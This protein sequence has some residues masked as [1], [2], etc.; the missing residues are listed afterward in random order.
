MSINRVALRNLGRNRVK[1]LLS[2]IAIIAGVAAYI[3]SS[4]FQK[5]MA[6]NGFLNI[7]NY[8]SGPIQ[9]YSKDYFE[10]KDEFPL[11]ETIKDG[12]IIE[13]ALTDN[14]FT[15]PRVRFQG[16]IISPSKE[17]NFNIIAVDPDKEKNLFLY[18]QDIT[19]RNIKNGNF[20]MVMGY[21]SALELGVDVGDPVR[22]V[23][24]IE[25]KDGDRIKTIT[26]IM[27]FTVV[28][29]IS[30]DNTVVS[31]NTAFVPLDVLQNETGMMFNG[32]VT[33]IVVRDKNSSY[34]SMPTDNESVEVIS[35]LLPEHLKSTLDVRNWMVYD[36]NQ[37]KS[38]STSDTGPIFFFMSLLIIML[39]S[40][41]ML[42][43]VMDRTKEIALLRAM[44]MDNF[45]IFKLLAAEAGYLGLF[46]AL[47][48]MVVGYFITVGK[49]N[50]GIVINTESFKAAGMSFTMTGTIKSAWSIKG[51]I[52]AGIGAIVISVLS[53]AFPT[54]SVLK[55]NI[56]KGIKHE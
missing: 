2:M 11:Y 4:C 18:T 27:D 55:M 9:I 54:L 5:G 39:M 23:A 49:V 22:L 45:E 3:M 15:A 29:L 17:K 48:G 41:T 16:S 35:N 24:Q 10:I 53:A 12:S 1:T 6:L 52:T 14:Y 42:L 33:E 7:I 8:E 31:T 46:G 37:I 43:S 20:E 26:Q 28:G 21:R 51:F 19:P 32:A 40:N 30:S 50:T 36:E 44:G 47:L 38:L 34:N 25:Y 56:I 13:E